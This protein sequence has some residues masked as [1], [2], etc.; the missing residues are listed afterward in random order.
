MVLDETAGDGKP[1]PRPTPVSVSRL[2]EPS[3]AVEHPLPLRGG[4]AR[5]VVCHDQLGGAAG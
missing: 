4:Y 2:V 1:E 5:T 3:E